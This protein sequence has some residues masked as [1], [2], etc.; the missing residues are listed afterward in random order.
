MAK[1]IAI[2]SRKSRFTG[3]GESIENQIELCRQYIDHSYQKEAPLEIL[4]YEDEGY[5]G[6]NTA[7]PQFKRM[8]QDARKKK[9]SVIVCYRL[10]RI[11]R[12][13]GDFAKMID[14]LNRM[15]IGFVSIRETFDTSTPI[16]Q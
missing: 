12:N 14:E 5:S 4:I 16:G 9:F 3:K 15:E 11:S 1:G 6:K 10:D 13:V 7:R 8:L 2:Y